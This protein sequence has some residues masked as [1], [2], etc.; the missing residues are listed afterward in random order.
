MLDVIETF[1]GPLS[2]LECLAEEQ[3][4]PQKAKCPLHARCREINEAVRETLSR[5]SLVDGLQ[6]LE[7]LRRD[8]PDDPDGC[9][10]KG[11]FIE[12]ELSGSRRWSC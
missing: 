6:Q 4:C 11:V 5:F 3:V 1:Q 8:N 2:L 9:L 12:N 7:D 10:R